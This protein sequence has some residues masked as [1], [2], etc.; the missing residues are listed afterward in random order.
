MHHK[1][2][3][4]LIGD[5][6][7]TSASAATH[8]QASSTTAAFIAPLPA[9]RFWSEKAPVSQQQGSASTEG[10]SLTIPTAACDHQEGAQAKCQRGHKGPLGHKPPAK[11]LRT[12]CGVPS[13]AQ[14][15][16]K[17][18]LPISERL[19]PGSACTG[20]VASSQGF[21]EASVCRIDLSGAALVMAQQ[22]ELT[23]W[24]GHSAPPVSPQHENLSFLRFFGVVVWFGFI[25]VRSCWGHG[26]SRT[27]LRVLAFARCG[28]PH[29]R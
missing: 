19:G 25:G 1:P 20:R 24:I 27:S 3:T 4:F 8:H 14:G 11:S 22:L 23:S 29:A 17:T 28:P 2:L 9:K 12:G 10:H 13:P 7:S 6:P 16:D 26:R 18:R 5:T 15:P 21:Q